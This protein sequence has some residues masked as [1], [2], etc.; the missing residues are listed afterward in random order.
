M[1]EK[2]QSSCQLDI[3]REC[4]KQLARLKRQAKRA[5]AN[6]YS[7]EQYLVEK[8]LVVEN[9]PNDVN[10]ILEFDW[11]EHGPNQIYVSDPHWYPI[12]LELVF[13][14][15]ARVTF[16]KTDEELQ[17]YREEHDAWFRE[18]INYCCKHEGEHGFGAKEF[19]DLETSFGV[20][21]YI[22]EQREY[23]YIPCLGLKG[24][25]SVGVYYQMILAAPQDLSISDREELGEAESEFER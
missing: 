3:K 16:N 23:V 25:V 13:L 21:I 12:L 20:A 2:N 8:K 22:N 11:E 15:M 24:T 18:S 19:S 6:P 7:Y 4:D 9:R 1:K 5:C 17:A 10:E 14:E